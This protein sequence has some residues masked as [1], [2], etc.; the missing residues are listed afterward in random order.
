MKNT[1][2]NIVSEALNQ[3]KME[4]SS[5]NRTVTLTDVKT[6]VNCIVDFMK[7]E[8]ETSKGMFLSFIDSELR[9]VAPYLYPAKMQ[10]DK[11]GN[12]TTNQ[13]LWA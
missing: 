9:V 7:F 4:V 1:I 12:Y 2:K 10:M 13:K 6:E 3:A 11:N 5:Y 8:T